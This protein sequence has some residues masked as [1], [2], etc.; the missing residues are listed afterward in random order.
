MSHDTGCIWAD[1]P[2]IA[3]IEGKPKYGLVQTVKHTYFEHC[4]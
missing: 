1:E 3:E 2:S 4:D